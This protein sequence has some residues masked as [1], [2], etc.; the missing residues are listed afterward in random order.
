MLVS[1]IRNIVCMEKETNNENHNTKNSTAS[2]IVTQQLQVQ[3]RMLN[4]LSEI[5]T[6]LLNNTNAN[7]GME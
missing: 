1:S 4:A 2:D 7:G 5:T 6:Q 3:E